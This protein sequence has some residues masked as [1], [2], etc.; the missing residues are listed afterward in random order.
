MSEAKTDACVWS[1]ARKTPQPRKTRPDIFFQ[2]KNL[3]S[4]KNENDKGKTKVKKVRKR[5][6]TKINKD[7][8]KRQK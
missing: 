4:K 6:N 3:F 5:P 7:G 8:G 1:K 2:K